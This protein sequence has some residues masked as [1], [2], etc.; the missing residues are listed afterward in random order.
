MMIIFSIFENVLLHFSY[1]RI[2]LPWN[3]RKVTPLI[4]FKI[5]RDFVSLDYIKQK[6]KK[7][8]EENFFDLQFKS[9]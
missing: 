2:L 7:K 5:I 3:E 9:K 6:K 1:I 4:T 8:K